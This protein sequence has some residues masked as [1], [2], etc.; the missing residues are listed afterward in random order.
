M[1][2]G[3]TAGNALIAVALNR[4]YNIISKTIE[5]ALEEEEMVRVREEVEEAPAPEPMEPTEP[6]EPVASV[7]I[8]LISC[9]RHYGKLLKIE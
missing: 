9:H 3:G 5:E 2:R 8:R 6:M 1:G 7:K 4:I